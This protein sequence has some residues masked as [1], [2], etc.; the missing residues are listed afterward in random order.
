MWYLQEVVLFK[1]RNDTIHNRNSDY[2][3][4]QKVVLKRSMKKA[5]S[6]EVNIGFE[7]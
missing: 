6:I 5:F 3:L 1:E 4:I 2:G 7:I